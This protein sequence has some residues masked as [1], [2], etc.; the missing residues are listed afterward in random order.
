MLPLSRPLRTR[1]SIADE[2]GGEEIL[3]PRNLHSAVVEHPRAKAEQELS[4]DDTPRAHRPPEHSVASDKPSILPPS[5]YAQPTRSARK[6]TSDEFE[7]D[8][9]GSLVSK[10]A[11]SSSSA[12]DKTREEKAA[13]ARRH[14][15]L[16]SGTNSSR[17]GKT[18]E[19]RRESSGLT[20]NASL[21]LSTSVRS[22]ERHVR[23]ASA[24]ST[25]SNFDTP[26]SRRGQTTDFLHLPPSP[27]STSIQQYLRSTPGK[28]P[29]LH[30]ASRDNLH[31]HASTNVAHALLRGTQEGWSA[32]DDEAAAEALRKLDG[33][34]GRGARACASVGS[35]GRPSSSSRPATPASKTGSQWDGTSDSAKSKHGSKDNA[36][37]KDVNRVVHNLIE[38]SAMATSSDDQPSHVAVLD[39]TPKKSGVRLSFTP[40]RGSTSSTTY[41]STPSSR[42]SASMSA[43]TSVTSVSAASGRQSSN[44][45]RRNS[46]G[47]DISSINSSE[48]QKDR[49]A[50]MGLNGDASDETGVPPVPPLPKDFSNYRSPPTSS[51]F[52]FPSMSSDDKDR[53]PKTDV[54][55]NRY[56]SLDVPPTPVVS[57]PAPSAHRDNQHY[58]TASGSDSLPVVRTPSKKWSF[59]SAL[60]LKLVSPSSSRQKSSAPMSPRSVTFGHQ[61]RK[62]NSKDQQ[63]TSLSSAQWSPNQPAAMNSMHSLASLSSVGSAASPNS[64]VAISAKMFDRTSGFSRPGTGSSISTNNTTSALTAP[65]PG[66]LSPAASVRRSHSKRLTP[67]SIPF[68]SRRSSSQSIHLPPPPPGAISSISPTSSGMLSAQTPRKQSGS[69]AQD[70]NAVSISTSTPGG[71]QKKSLLGLPSLLKSSSRRSLHSDAKDSDKEIKK[72]KAAVREAEKVKNKLEKQRKEDKDRSESRISV[73]INRKRGKVGVLC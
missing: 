40:K 58:L 12:K 45:G 51:G 59:S 21:K 44:K 33:L 13:A 42:D 30:R 25:T 70:Y 22:P 66:P 34:S 62:T 43:A 54:H 23:Q 39:K 56:I 35:F 48:V 16:T 67:S 7:F 9:T 10:Y 31:S 73:L 32:L 2:S 6:R 36:S 14:R 46:A 65:Q 29:S 20:L 47:S 24:G 49:A 8:Q 3:Y 26:P 15:S 64:N 68:F 28:S 72:A 61:L 55:S 60:N 38:T 50:L 4:F 57:P 27:S 53:V 52:V 63:F 19:R 18:K 17:D 41:A 1:P 37:G 11:S 69:P 71:T 5:S